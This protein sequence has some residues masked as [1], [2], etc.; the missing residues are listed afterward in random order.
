MNDTNI[1]C[2]KCAA[3]FPLGEAVSHRLCEQIKADF[4][5]ERA[6]LNVSVTPGAGMQ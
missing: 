6:Q 2:P 1:T 4:N 3:E 5:R